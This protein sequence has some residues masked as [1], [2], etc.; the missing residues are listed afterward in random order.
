MSTKETKPSISEKKVV[1]NYSK[2]KDDDDAQVFQKQ[3]YVDY[4]DDGK[5]ATMTTP[6]ISRAN[7]NDDDKKCCVIL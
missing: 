4:K 7:D 1:N 2:S 5:D 3:P 6:L